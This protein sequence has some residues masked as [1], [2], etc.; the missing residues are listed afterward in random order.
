MGR[1]P[2]TPYTVPPPRRSFMFA[3]SGQVC[4][5]KPFLFLLSPLSSPHSCDSHSTRS[6]SHSSNAANSSC[7]SHCRENGGPVMHHPL[8]A[9]SSR[10]RASVPMQRLTRRPWQIFEAKVI[11]LSD[12]ESNLKKFFLLE[13]ALRPTN[14]PLAAALLRLRRCCALR[15][16][17]SLSRAPIVAKRIR[18]GVIRIPGTRRT[19]RV[20][21]IAAK[22]EADAN[23]LADRCS[24]IV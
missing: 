22:T 12:L 3:V 21:R 5:T 14:L 2:D 23:A 4:I 10:F 15:A 11:I 7:C 9:T 18:R 6:Y 1:L 24:P 17:Q 8:S 13:S 19:V 16:N 20:G